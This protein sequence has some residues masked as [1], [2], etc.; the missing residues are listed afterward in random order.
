[1]TTARLIVLGTS[2]VLLTIAKG[3]TTYLMLESAFTNKDDK[4]QLPY[5]VLLVM[6]KAVDGLLMTANLSTRSGLKIIYG[7][8]AARLLKGTAECIA[9]YTFGVGEQVISI[10]SAA[11][12]LI[13]GNVS[14]FFSFRSYK[15]KVQEKA[16]E[17][18]QKSQ[19]Q[20]KSDSSGQGSYNPPLPVVPTG[21]DPDPDTV[22]DMIVSARE[23][24]NSALLQKG[25]NPRS[26][27]R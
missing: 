2:Q 1:M 17:E 8:E 18:E 27:K 20:E 15:Q 21:S 22:V 13:P 14:S 24:E 4:E 5:G 3:Y 16:S 10:A 25:S 19:S 11:Y 23:R 9:Y 12:D 7:L 26:S 6:N